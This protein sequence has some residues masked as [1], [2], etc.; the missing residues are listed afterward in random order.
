MKMQLHNAT[1]LSRTTISE[2]R[3]HD[4]KEAA[5]WCCMAADKGGA[6]GQYHVDRMEELC[7]EAGPG[8]LEERWQRM[9]VASGVF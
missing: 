8:A 5:W 1:W 3:P 7:E 2:E 9:L 6:E 4:D